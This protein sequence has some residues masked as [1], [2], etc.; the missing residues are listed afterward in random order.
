MKND[1]I[2]Q[3]N[4]LTT[5]RYEMSSLQKDIVYIMI[6]QLHDN[7]GHQQHKIPISLL[8]EKKGV[9][10]RREK[11]LSAARK[12]MSSG[13]RIYDEQQQKFVVVGILSHADYDDYHLVLEFDEKIYPFFLNLKE[14][15]TTFLLHSALSLKSRYSKRLYEMLSQFK[16]TKVL[17]ITVKELKM[18]LGL[19]D[20]ITLKERYTDFNM[21]TKKVLKVAQEEIPEHTELSF[22][23]TAKKTGRKYTDLIFN[24]QY[25]KPTS[26]SKEK[27]NK[28][29]SQ[30]RL[31]QKAGKYPN[32]KL[33]PDAWKLYS[34]LTAEV[35]WLKPKLAYKLVQN[36]SLNTLWHYIHEYQMLMKRQEERPSPKDFFQKKL[37]L[38][39]HPS[40]EAIYRRSLEIKGNPNLV[41][42]PSQDIEQRSILGVCY[43]KMAK[44]GMPHSAIWEITREIREKVKPE[45]LHAFLEKV[46]A[47]MT[48][49]E[50]SQSD[51]GNYLKERLRKEYNLSL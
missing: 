6:S 44:L 27:L 5:A 2:A 26:D 34:F 30:P 42:E 46:S 13:V 33:T 47:E 1:L 29:L 49:K 40:T 36:V 24:I 14:R 43:T 32:D 25:L 21:F 38:K 51:N 39:N 3:H 23:Y 28:T 45:E 50:V 9:R 12:L 37:E 19:I 17:K 35:R 18:R 15:F 8:Q 31:Q 10:V 20:P 11:A 4:L 22:T 16:D 41:Q 7:R 48:E